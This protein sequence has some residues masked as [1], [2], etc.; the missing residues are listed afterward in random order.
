M[1]ARAKIASQVAQ[2]IEVDKVENNPEATKKSI[3]DNE[4][5]NDNNVDEDA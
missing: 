2:N 3:L 4:N 5:I 1:I